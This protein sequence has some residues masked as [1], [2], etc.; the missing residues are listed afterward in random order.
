MADEND[1]APDTDDT[2]L[3]ISDEDAER[4]LADAVD[5]DSSDRGGRRDEDDDEEDGGKLRDAGK[6]A[7]EAMKEQRKAARAERDRARKE[8]DE[9]RRE[10]DKFKNANKSEL[11]RLIDERD[12]LKNRLSEVSSSAKR[13]EVAEEFAPEHATTRQIRLVAKYLAGSTDEELEAS[14]EELFAQ[15]A[16]EPPKARTPERP[17]EA[18]KRPKGGSDPDDEPEELDPRKLASAIRAKRL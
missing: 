11:Q 12:E 2:D 7:L 18:L 8:L 1:N 14:A 16:P 3:G 9:V 15:F 10:L 5:E 17:R 13:R 6:R 4:L